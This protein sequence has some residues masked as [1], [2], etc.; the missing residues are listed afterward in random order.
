MALDD[1]AGRRAR[2]VCDVSFVYDENDEAGLTSAGLV[3]MV[4]IMGA[5][6][7]CSRS[8]PC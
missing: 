5:R 6:P 3:R 7:D 4:L 1:V 2:G 8:L